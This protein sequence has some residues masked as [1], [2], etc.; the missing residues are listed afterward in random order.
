MKKHFTEA[1][2]KV[3]TDMLDGKQTE[4]VL[5]LNR[6][7]QNTTAHKEI[8]DTLLTVMKIKE[9]ITYKTIM[10]GIMDLLLKEILSYA[11]LNGWTLDYFYGNSFIVSRPID[12]AVRRKLSILKND[13][14][15][16]GYKYEELPADDLAV[17][18]IYRR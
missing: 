12:D 16:N 2:K 14:I 5:L 17:I 9:K 15:S 1:E 13:A 18:M 10:W 8:C 6:L 7:N 4:L 3:L 11:E